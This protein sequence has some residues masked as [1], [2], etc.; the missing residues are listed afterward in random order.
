MKAVFLRAIEA[1][2]DEKAEV[3]RRALNTAAEPGTRFVVELESFRQVPRSPFAYWVSDRVRGLFA[4]LPAFESEGRTAQRALSTND[5]FRYLRLAWERFADQADIRPASGWLPFAKGGS[6]GRFYSDIHL[7]VNWIGEGRE[8]E[9]DAIRKYPYLKGNAEWVLHRECNYLRPG[10]T[11]PLRT[12][13]GLSF[14]AMP[15]G[16][17]FGHKGPTGFVERDRSDE[18]LSL[19]S[20]TNSSS[21][22]ALVELQMA[23]GSYEVGVIQRTPVPDLS[24]EQQ[25]QLADLAHRAWS[26]KRT[27]DTRVETSHAFSVPAL[28]QFEGADLQQRA[29]AW[30]D[31]AASNQQALDSLQAEIDVLCFDLYGIGPEDR[32]RIEAGG[33]G[34][35]G[36]QDDAIDEDPDDDEA[37]DVDAAPMVA[38]LLAWCVGVAF[39]R[40]DLRLATGERPMPAEPEPFDPLPVCSPGMLT[41]DDGLPLGVPPAEYSIGFP[42][43]GILVDDP[44]HPS[45]LVQAVR[46]LFETLFDEADARWHEA[47][48]LLGVDDPR[49][50][51]AS[52]FFEQHIKRYSKSRRKAPIYWQLATTSG[53]YS[54][55]L[56][57]HR[58]TS[59]TLFRVLNDYLGP[60]LDH[61]QTRLTR[62]VQA[63]GVT[64]TA[65]QRREI[66]PQE[67]LVEELKALTSEVARV[68]P[69]WRPSL[70]DGVLINF[71]P[72]W[73]LTPQSRSWQTECRKT[74]DK[75][76]AG[77]CDWSQL[78]MHLWPERVVPKCAEDRSLAIAHGLETEL[79]YKDEDEN[80]QPRP[81]MDARIGEPTSERVSTTVKAALKDLLTAPAPIVPR[82]ARR[83]TSA[84]GARRQRTGQRSGAASTSN[85]APG[86][87]DADLLEAV[88]GA[89]AQQ[90][91]EVSKS[92]V[93]AATGLTDAQWNAAIAALLVDG[94][95]TKSGAGRGTRYH[96]LNPEP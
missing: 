79:W 49:D 80:W 12:Q 56:Y 29:E 19:L 4:D 87:P 95:V 30:S 10:L 9:A 17:I 37:M 6:F 43:D 77:D 96:L 66:E 2:V 68:A 28:L 74:W 32:Q 57:V 61:E 78:S 20:I 34:A 44:G 90:G 82:A 94:S 21:F 71:A 46:G 42:A 67:S 48:E 63:V 54:V 83:A 92:D 25:T 93:L 14:R 18:L 91:G 27:L 16:G 8:I 47:A 86:W 15:R 60:K 59:D 76:Q 3:L 38:S 85:R 53:R 72:L 26:L 41:G 81:A 55:W 39:G 50:W 22:S 40:F 62:L 64:P 75:L 84:S 65:A 24:P 35:E 31:L 73:R 36:G 52:S 7:L 13:A 1:P 58:A 69:L 5:D 11:W 88:R 45:D 51:F 70:D 89:I 23:F 33:I